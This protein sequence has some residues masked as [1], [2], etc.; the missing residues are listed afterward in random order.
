MKR[1]NKCNLSSLIQHSLLFVLLCLFLSSPLWLPILCSCI[2]LF[3]MESLPKIINIV[4]GP[5]SLFLVFNLIIII[6]IGESRLS[7]SSS[8]PNIYEEYVIY[9]QR[10]KE[11]SKDNPLVEE[12]KEIEN[13]EEKEETKGEE[14]VINGVSEVLEEEEE[15]KKEEE[16]VI[17]GEREVIEEEE[18]EKKEEEEVIKG[19]SK[20]L[21]EEEEERGLMPAEELNKRVEDFIARVNMQRRLEERML[22]GLR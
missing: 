12:K 13:E 14:E 18:E 21:I 5:K 16:E 6:L 2:K 1:Y 7:S 17:K 22:V 10:Y 11:V 8:K 4:I 3:F 15:E 20:V 19:E 9:S